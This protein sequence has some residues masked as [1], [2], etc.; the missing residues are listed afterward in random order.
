M[1]KVQHCRINLQNHTFK[2]YKNSRILNTLDTDKLL[3]IYDRY[4][5][6]HNFISPFPFYK[7]Q[8]AHI[9]NN[10]IGYTH[11]NKLVAWS[12]IYL[13][14]NEIVDSQQFAW[15]YKNP[16]LK[17]G[18]KSIENEAA[19]YKEK[20]FKYMI[21]GEADNYKKSVKGFELI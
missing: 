11:N 4:C 8:F 7:E 18:Y 15:N 20:G 13:V 9:Y 6:Y 12:M 2:K 19:I 17:L 1:N 16:E 5:E 21:L 14:N 3:E 10:I